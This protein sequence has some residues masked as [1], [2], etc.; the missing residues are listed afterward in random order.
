MEEQRE[1]ARK[2]Q[3]KEV[4]ELSQLETTTRPDSLDMNVSPQK[5]RFWRW[6]L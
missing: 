5:Q 4:I 3:K 2:A 1:R 6:S